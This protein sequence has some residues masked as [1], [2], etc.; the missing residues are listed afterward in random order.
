MAM[1]RQRIA[2]VG[3]YFGAATLAFVDPGVRCVRAGL[4]RGIELSVGKTAEVMRIL[5]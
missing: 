1:R 5:V 3:N 2:G 4:M